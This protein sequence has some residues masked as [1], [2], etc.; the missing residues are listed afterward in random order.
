MQCSQQQM[1]GPAPTARSAPGGRVSLR[2]NALFK[3]SGSGKPAKEAPP[4]PAKKAKAV[5]KKERCV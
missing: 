1:R 5:A 4:P 2:V 3:R